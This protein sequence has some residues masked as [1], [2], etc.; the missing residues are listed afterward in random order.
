MLFG[1]LYLLILSVEQSQI[2]CE[3]S[4]RVQPEA[5]MCLLREK[6]R[7]LDHPREESY[8]GGSNSA[9]YNF[10]VGYLSC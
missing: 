5:S 6:E 7:E 10:W 1:E 8:G 9:P 3:F 2:H 4:E